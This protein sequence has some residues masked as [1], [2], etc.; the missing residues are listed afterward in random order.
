MKRK[1]RIEVD[2][3]GEEEIIIR[4]RQMDED[5]IRVQ[6]LLENGSG[7]RP[8]EITLRLG[9]TEYIVPVGDVIF[10]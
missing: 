10:F 2:P 5:V 3:D 1:I 6:K 9:E 4:C 7:N 8:G